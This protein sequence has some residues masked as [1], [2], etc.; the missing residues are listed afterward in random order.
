MKYI[1]VIVATI[2]A[3]DAVTAAKVSEYSGTKVLP[4]SLCSFHAW[5]RIILK[6]KNDI[7]ISRMIIGFIIRLYPAEITLS[8][9]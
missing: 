9:A 6:P 3:L 8:C 2:N 1:A 4:P 5:W 7:I